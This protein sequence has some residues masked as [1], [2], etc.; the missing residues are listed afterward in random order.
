MIISLSL[1]K[2]LWITTVY[3]MCYI[4]KLALP[5]PFV[6]ALPVHFLIF[7]ANKAN[8]EGDESYENK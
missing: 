3:E 8:P 6:F 4:N 5:N 7:S 2:A 1:S